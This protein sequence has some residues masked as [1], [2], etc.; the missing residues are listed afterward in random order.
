MAFYSLS[1]IKSFHA[2]A[3]KYFIV[4]VIYG[5]DSNV[6]TFVRSSPQSPYHNFP[7]LTKVVVALV[8]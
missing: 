1:F 8:F 2:V 4:L 3:Q 5:K 7:I 6:R